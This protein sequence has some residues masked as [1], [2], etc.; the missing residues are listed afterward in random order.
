MLWT[1]CQH[2]P[3]SGKCPTKRCREVQNKSFTLKLTKLVMKMLESKFDILLPPVPSPGYV[4]PLPHI[5]WT[6]TP[7]VGERVCVSFFLA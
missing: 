6:A 4:K 5:H 7:W 1:I 2:L 3:A